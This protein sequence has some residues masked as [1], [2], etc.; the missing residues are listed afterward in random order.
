MLR[1]RALKGAPRRDNVARRG[2][3][4]MEYVFAGALILLIVAALALAVWHTFIRNPSKVAKIDPQIHFRCLKCGGEYPKDRDKLTKSQMFSE[5][6]G[7][8]R[9]DCPKC[10]TKGAG[11][12]LS[13]CPECGKNYLPKFFTNQRLWGQPGSNICEHCKI[14]VDKWYM[15]DAKK[16][17]K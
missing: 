6:E 13:K 2:V 3:I 14:D 15:E 1:D 16:R 11:I 17:K 10:A 12:Q 9:D 8:I 4:N 5:A 7:P